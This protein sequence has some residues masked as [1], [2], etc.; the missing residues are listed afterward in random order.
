MYKVET[1]EVNLFYGD[2]RALKS[3]TMG[4]DENK[5][6]AMIGPSGC[7]KS[8]YLRLFNR[9]ND[10]IPDFLPDLTNVNINCAISYNDLI[11]PYFIQYLITWENSSGL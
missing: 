2:N 4:I 5:V 7:G 6:V 3:V 8:T 10:M 11:T 1:R 9:M